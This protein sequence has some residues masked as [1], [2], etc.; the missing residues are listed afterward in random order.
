MV[1]SLSFNVYAL[2]ISLVSQLG[3][4][5][6]APTEGQVTLLNSLKCAGVCIRLF[7][8]GRSDAPTD[9][10][11]CLFIFVY[12]QIN[13]LRIPCEKN[14]ICS[15]KIKCIKKLLNTEIIFLGK[16]RRTLLSDNSTQMAPAAAGGWGRDHLASI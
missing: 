2:L 9:S 6:C 15:I 8:S 3:Q 11:V 12:Q 4:T 14:H 7:Y 1:T 5:R 10:Y 16:R 13:I